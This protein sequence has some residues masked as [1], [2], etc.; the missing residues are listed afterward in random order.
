[1]AAAHTVY[2]E[3]TLLT[4]D[5][6]ILDLPIGEG[7]AVTLD[8]RADQRGSLSLSV[9]LGGDTTLIP[10]SE[11]DAL[12]PYGS[13]IT[14]RRGGITPAG[15]TEQVQIGVFW[16]DEVQVA[17]DGPD[18]TVEISG[19]DH[20]SRIIDAVFEQPGTFAAG[21]DA[22][23]LAQLVVAA[24]DPLVSFN[25]VD[26][27]VTLP[28][29]G[30]E[31]G[32]DR[33]DFARGCAEAAGCELYFD[34]DDYCIA[35]PI[36]ETDAVD[37]E[38]VEGEGG[39]LLSAS[40]SWSREDAC[41]RVTV[42]GENGSDDPVWGEAI[43]DD[44]TSPTHYF[45]PF[46]KVTFDWSSEYVTTDEEAAAVAQNI[47]AQ[48]RGTGQQIDF[49]ALANPALEPGDVVRVR[50]TRLGIDELHVIDSV[51]IPLDNGGDMTC[52]T[53]VQRVI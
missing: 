46:G 37:L 34:G 43:D 8:G 16:I 48:K 1:M 9:P 36:A 39:I 47:L 29:L 18:L 33:W 23:E 49:T 19:L 6:E 35:R 41:S 38:V 26:T 25:F 32:D 40:R 28:M 4:P 44:P 52:S 24:A 21:L 22:L 12:A 14:I 3:A 5:G 11:A 17:D 10:E 42:Q 27:D 15:V 20:S 31:A 30:Y 50:R 51:S 53:R 7:S 2:A 13:T 45:G